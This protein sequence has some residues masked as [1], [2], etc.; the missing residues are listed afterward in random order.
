MGEGKGV[1]FRIKDF[2][3]NVGSYRFFFL[4]FGV[5]VFEEG[6]LSGYC[7]WYLFF[8]WGFDSLLVVVI[9]SL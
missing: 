2:F 3:Y 7:I 9:I 4:Y 1:G 8:G 6:I 5:V